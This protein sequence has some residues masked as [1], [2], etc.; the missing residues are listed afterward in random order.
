MREQKEERMSLGPR[1]FSLA[2][3]LIVLSAATAAAEPIRIT[4]GSLDW[5]SGGQALTITMAGDGFTFV[6]LTSRVEGV[7]GPL[8]QCGFPDCRAGTTV[9]LNSY[10]VGNGLSGT[11]TLDGVTYSNVG[12]GSGTSSLE[13]RWTGSLRIP[14]GFT[15]GTLFA[16]FQFLGDFDYALGLTLPA[17]SV[18]LFGSGTASL[19]FGAWP[20]GLFPGALSINAVT[21]TFEPAAATPEPASLLLLGTGVC[22]LAAARRRSHA[23]L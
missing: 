7:F 22:A 17:Q 6:G 4:S 20:S 16:P 5:R 8:E 13:A 21:Y 18:D 10:F 1:P 9:D 11:A 15:G 3:A 19:T 12:S 2:A 23:R 14:A